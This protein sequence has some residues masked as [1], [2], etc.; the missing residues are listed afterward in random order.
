MD[1]YSNYLSKS[2]GAAA[3]PF[4]T[5]KGRLSLI[6]GTGISESTTP[7]ATMMDRRKSETRA[8]LLMLSIGKQ[9]P[10]DPQVLKPLENSLK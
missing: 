9:Y 3:N 8:K 6:F 10:H 7:S 4:T 2:S 1:L 5:E